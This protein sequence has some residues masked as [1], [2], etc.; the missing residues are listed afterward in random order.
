MCRV[1]LGRW[2]IVVEKRLDAIQLSP[3][4]LVLLLR[5]PL[6]RRLV[7]ATTVCWY[8]IRFNPNPQMIPGLQLSHWYSVERWRAIRMDRRLRS[9]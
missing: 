8:S 5:L 1:W 3:V 4:S 9:R 6:I 7:T 2:L